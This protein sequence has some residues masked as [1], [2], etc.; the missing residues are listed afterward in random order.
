MLIYDNRKQDD[1]KCV[2]SSLAFAVMV[3]C[4]YVCLCVCVDALSVSLSFLSLF[5]LCLFV[6]LPL[7]PSICFSFSLFL[8]LSLCPSLAFCFSVYRSVFLALSLSFPPPHRHTR[9]CLCVFMY[10]SLFH[11]YVE[12]PLFSSP[13]YP[14]S[15]SCSPSHHA[16]LLP[17]ST[18]FVF[19]L[20]FFSHFSLLI[21]TFSVS[22]FFPSFFWVFGDGYEARS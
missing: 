9:L 18:L 15:L 11:N 19:T 13:F 21:S 1:S 8:I 6:S 22:L 3:K 10:L 5:R 17:R 12:F 14:L 2:I 4:K 16:S 20:L 7:S